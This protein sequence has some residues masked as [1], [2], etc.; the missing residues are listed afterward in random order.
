MRQCS[1]FRTPHRFRRQSGVSD[2]RRRSAHHR[3]ERERK[4]ERERLAGGMEAGA[5][6]FSAGLVYGPKARLRTDGA[7]HQEEGEEAEGVMC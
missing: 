3:R 5:I 7:F 1:G 4:R 6:S 2:I